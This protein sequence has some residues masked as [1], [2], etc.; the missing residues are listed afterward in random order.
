MAGVTGKLGVIVRKD[1]AKQATYNGHPLCTYISDTAPGQAKGDG[2]NLFGGSGTT[3]SWPARPRLPRSRPSPQAAEATG[4][5]RGRQGKLRPRAQL[6]PVAE[7]SAHRG[8][9]Q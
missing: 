1:G 2:L 8:L 9:L 5:Y 7:S 4:A 3:S 6:W